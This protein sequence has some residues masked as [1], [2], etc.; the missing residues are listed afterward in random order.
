[1]SSALSD[2]IHPRDLEGGTWRE[3]ETFAITSI[4]IFANKLR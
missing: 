1:M 3:F 2:N 4:R